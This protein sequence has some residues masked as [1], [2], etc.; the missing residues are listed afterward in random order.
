M[1][2][3]RLPSLVMHQN[4]ARRTWSVLFAPFETIARELA[5]PMS[6]EEIAAEYARLEKDAADAHRRKARA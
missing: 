3:F 1:G 6:D 5:R 4:G 2:I